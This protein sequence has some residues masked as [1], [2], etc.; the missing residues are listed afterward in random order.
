VKKKNYLGP[1]NLP[2]GVYKLGSARMELSLREGTGADTNLS[3]GKMQIG[4]DER[5]WNDI[6]ISLL[7]EVQE[8]CMNQMDCAYRHYS[9]YG[10]SG[11]NFSFILTHEQFNEI[12]CRSGDLIAPALP[13][14]SRAWVKW[15][16]IK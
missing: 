16:K 14:L 3:T 10:L 5:G 6:V 4:A 2:V 8:V 7:H 12:C 15:K 1:R 13:D 9:Y 11:S